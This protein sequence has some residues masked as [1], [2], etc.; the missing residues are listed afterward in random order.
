MTTQLRKNNGSLERL[1]AAM[2]PERLLLIGRMTAIKKRYVTGPN[3]KALAEVIAPMLDGQAAFD[4]TDDYAA[5]ALKHRVVFVI[6]DS[7]SGKSTAIK[8]ILAKSD[9]LQPFF[10]D[11][12]QEI[13][14]V[15][16]FKAPKPMTMKLLAKTGLRAIGYPIERDRPENEMWDL[17][18]EQLP[19]R[20]VLWVHVDEMQHAIRNSGHAATQDIA[21]V[22][23]NLMQLEDWPLMSILSGVTSVASFLRFDDTQLRNR[24]QIVRFERL[25][26]GDGTVRLQRVIE[27]VV[28]K[29]AEMKPGDGILSEEFANRLIQATSGGFGT[30]IQ[31]TREAIFI[32]LRQGREEVQPEDFSIFYRR[33]SGCRPDEDI[34]TSPN[35]SAIDSGNA[36]R[37]FIVMHEEKEAALRE[38]TKRRKG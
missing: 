23:K 1:R 11:D 19:E 10:D 32:A 36:I 34:F 31:F 7:G 12:G 38:S 20:E 28:T 25:N 9:G 14:P 18:R 26:R 6:G 16:S 37:D 24:C 3:D 33:A 8:R 15:A 5:E 13:R 21:D 2:P 27:G 30:A 22:V 35:W 29:H 17:F 4:P